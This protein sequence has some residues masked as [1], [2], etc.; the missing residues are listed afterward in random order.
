MREEDRHIA[1]N[2]VSELHDVVKGVCLRRDRGLSMKFGQALCE[3]RH[4][5]DG[6]FA[7]RNERRQL[8]R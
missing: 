7:P 2:G 6:D 8:L 4:L 3:H 5:T 1:E